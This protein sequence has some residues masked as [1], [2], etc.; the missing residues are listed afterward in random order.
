MLRRAVG[1]VLCC[2]GLHAWV[3]AEGTRRYGPH[4]NLRSACLRP[5]CDAISLGV[6][7]RA[8]IVA[9]KFALLE[10]GPTTG[11]VSIADLRVLPPAKAQP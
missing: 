6:K 10:G 1:W 9:E 4:E 3:D 2:C 7:D 5:D 8:A 11:E